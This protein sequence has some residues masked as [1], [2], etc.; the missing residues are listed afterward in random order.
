MSGSILSLKHYWHITGILQ[1]IFAFLA[2]CMMLIECI[3]FECFIVKKIS[4]L[5]LMFMVQVNCILGLLIAVNLT[6]S[7]MINEYPQTISNY[8]AVN[9]LY[10]VSTILLVIILIGKYP[11]YY[12][13]F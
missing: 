5:V 1:I 2:L 12:F 7:P 9:M 13:T 3:E 10:D 4:W 6:T 8:V 11:D